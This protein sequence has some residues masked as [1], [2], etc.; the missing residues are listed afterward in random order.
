MAVTL[1]GCTNANIQPNSN[2][3]PRAQAGRTG[4]GEHSKVNGSARQIQVMVPTA[5]YDELMTALG[6]RDI[7][8]AV[9]DSLKETLR[10][11]R[12]KRDLE[13]GAPRRKA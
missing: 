4:M 7:N 10:K 8:D 1:F 9:L 5:L 6:E 12:F 13:R 3:T 2:A 11:L